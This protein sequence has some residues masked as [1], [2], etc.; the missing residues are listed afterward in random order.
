MRDYPTL[1]WATSM[2]D[3]IVKSAVC[4]RVSQFDIGVKLLGLLSCQ[5][6]KQD[7]G[8]HILIVVSSILFVV[9]THSIGTFERQSTQGLCHSVN[10]KSFTS[11]HAQGAV[12]LSHCALKP[13][14]GCFCLTSASTC[15]ALL[16]Y[17][18]YDVGPVP[19]VKQYSFRG[20][21]QAKVAL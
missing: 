6:C 12:L 5:P 3:G 7:S 21:L 14:S 4:C 13:F 10:N 8:I 2:F 15:R 16:G 17:P 11:A 1:S 18:R 20:A 9:S 19:L